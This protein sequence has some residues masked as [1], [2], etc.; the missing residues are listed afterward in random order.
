VDVPTV[1]DRLSRTLLR[2]NQQF[3][4]AEVD[5]QLGGWVHAVVAEY[6]EAGRFVAIGGLV[7][8]KNHRR[9]GLG[10][11]LMEHAEFFTCAAFLND[12]VTMLCAS[13]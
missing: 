8:D 13:K 10:R 9:K 3:M 5:S 11:E 1:A 2:T 6:I 7:V 4:V 12:V